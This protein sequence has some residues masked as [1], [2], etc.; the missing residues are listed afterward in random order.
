MSA[1]VRMASLTP[2]RVLRLDRE[3][4]SLEK[5]KLANLA[6][7][8]ERFNAV[9]AFVRGGQIWGRSPEGH[10]AHS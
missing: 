4:G 6:I 5:G 8:D 1:A 9:A 2:A 10:P 3:I 7:F